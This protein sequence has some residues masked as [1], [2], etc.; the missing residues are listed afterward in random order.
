MQ[1]NYSYE[2]DKEEGRTLDEDSTLQ[3]Q[4]REK[5]EIKDKEY[6]PQVTK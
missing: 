2:F 3:P 6:L 5:K 4:W 1:K